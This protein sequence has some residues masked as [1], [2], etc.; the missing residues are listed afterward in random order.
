[1]RLFLIT[2]ST[3]ERAH[4]PG[5]L[6]V[7]GLSMWTNENT[8]EAVFGKFGPMTAGKELLEPTGLP[9]QTKSIVN[10][11]HC[12]DKWKVSFCSSKSYEQICKFLCPVVK[13]VI[14]VS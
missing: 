1:M 3:M 9:A 7:G 8:R 4:R 5:K 12:P 13:V 14:A 11:S 2:Y 10:I 6:L